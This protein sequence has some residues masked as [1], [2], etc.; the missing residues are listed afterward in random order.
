MA[1][2]TSGLKR[3][4]SEAFSQASSF[5]LSSSENDSNNIQMSKRQKIDEKMNSFRSGLKQSVDESKALVISS[6]SKSNSGSYQKKVW[7][8][9]QKVYRFWSLSDFLD[10]RVGLLK[11]QV[12]IRLSNELDI[13]EQR[14]SAPN[15]IFKFDGMYEKYHFLDKNCKTIFLS[16]GEFFAM[17]KAL[18]QIVEQVSKTESGESRTFYLREFTRSEL[19][20]QKNVDN[21]SLQTCYQSSQHVDNICDC[22]ETTNELDTRKT[23]SVQ[24]SGKKRAV[25]LK[26]YTLSAGANQL[27]QDVLVSSKIRFSSEE[28]MQL[29]KKISEIAVH[30]YHLNRSFRIMKPVLFN[31][32]S[33]V[34]VNMLRFSNDFTLSQISV[35]DIHY[36][37]SFN[38]A[39]S[40][41]RSMGYYQNIISEIFDFIEKEG[42]NPGEVEIY[43]LYSHAL[44]QTNEIYK[45]TSEKIERIKRIQI[46]D[47]IESS[48]DM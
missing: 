43:S 30:V 23:I 38:N 41:M 46:N 8:G 17:K 44:S 28:I 6:N 15:V 13:A 24:G 2:V 27:D 1:S 42:I 48:Q 29:N 25:Y 37:E 39:F 20:N 35:N 16:V 22:Y 26:T 19:A 4:G 36:I 31:I 45:L 3:T 14:P 10:V 7:S 9:K 47:S 32:I 12:M 33:E 11:G 34:L 21:I 5:L 40:E 18:P